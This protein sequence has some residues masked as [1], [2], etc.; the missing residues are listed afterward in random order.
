MIFELACEIE[1]LGFDYSKITSR[2][3]TWDFKWIQSY[4]HFTDF[5]IAVLMSLLNND[6]DPINKNTGLSILSI[7]LCELGKH[8]Q[9]LE[10]LDLIS[11]DVEANELPF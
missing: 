11:E 3:D 2:I 8:N 6:I 10:V 1:L 5:S 7:R 4:S 9:S